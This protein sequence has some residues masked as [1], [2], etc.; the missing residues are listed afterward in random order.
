MFTVKNRLSGEFG[1]K[2]GF[3]PAITGMNEADIAN[4]AEGLVFLVLPQSLNRC[5]PVVELRMS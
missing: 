5:D 3:K 2:A 4:Y 1:T